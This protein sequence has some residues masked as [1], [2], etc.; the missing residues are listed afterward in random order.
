MWSW[1]QGRH[2]PKNRTQPASRLVEDCVVRLL[3][4]A[5]LS[6]AACPG[7]GDDTPPDGGTPDSGKGPDGCFDTPSTADTGVNVTA[8]DPTRGT[9]CDVVTSRYCVFDFTEDHGACRCLG[10]APHELGQGCSALQQDCAPG[11]VCINIGDGEICYQAC[12]PGDPTRCDALD[13][14]EETFLC[15][16][17]IRPDD[18]VTMNYG[19]CFGG[20]AC[21]PLDDRCAA[22]ETCALVSAN[23]NVCAPA[24]SVPIG[25]D[26]STEQCAKGG[27]CV[28]LSDADG[29]PIGTDCYEPCDVAAPACSAGTCTDVGIEGYGLCL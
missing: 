9:G 1:S 18:S 17:L 25:G 21:D 26:C 22:D 24:G 4:L 27:V 28:T 14:A 11:L 7:G 12:E 2:C 16:A 20:R 8:C 10:D 29:N 15:S 3:L 13:S 23:A 19:I 6:L 5:A